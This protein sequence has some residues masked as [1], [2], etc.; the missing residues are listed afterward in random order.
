MS[1]CGLCKRKHEQTSL[2]QNDQ[3]SW[4]D[5]SRFAN[6]GRPQPQP[7]QPQHEQIYR[8]RDEQPDPSRNEHLQAGSGSSVEVGITLSM[9]SGF[10]LWLTMI[11]TKRDG[12]FTF[13]DM[14]TSKDYNIELGAPLNFRYLTDI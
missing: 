12:L 9:L 11:D 4:T 7:D 2:P 10:G 6:M 5:L 13:G 14:R 3:M 1:W 8:T